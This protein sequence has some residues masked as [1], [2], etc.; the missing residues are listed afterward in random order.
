M[1]NVV[2]YVAELTSEELELVTGGMVNPPDK[3]RN[4]I[5]DQNEPGYRGPILWDLAP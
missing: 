4:G 3:N 5:P 2:N 1:Q